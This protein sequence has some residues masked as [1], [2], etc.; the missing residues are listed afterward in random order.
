MVV[1]ETTVAPV[2]SIP[3][4]LAARAH[5]SERGKNPA[6]GTKDLVDNQVDGRRLC[7]EL[8]SH[9]NGATRPWDGPMSI[10]ARKVSL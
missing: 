4:D 2:T 1:V 9:G 3:D 10:Q 8:V 7:N 5:E 6:A